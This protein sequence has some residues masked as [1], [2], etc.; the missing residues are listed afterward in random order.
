MPPNLAF[1][2]DRLTA[3][4]AEANKAI[5]AADKMIKAGHFTGA[6]R[7]TRTVDGVVFVFPK[8]AAKRAT[9]EIAAA[10]GSQTYV[11]NADGI[12]RVRLDKR[13]SAQDPEVTFSRKPLYIVPDLQP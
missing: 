2:Y 6:P 12:A 1:R 8:A 4:V 7:I 11:A 10:T 5:G 9:V 3:G 13:L